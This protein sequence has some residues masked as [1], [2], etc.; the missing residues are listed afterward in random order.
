[1][2]VVPRAIAFREGKISGLR[3]LKSV[4]VKRY[5]PL[6]SLFVSN[7][8]IVEGGS[9]FTKCGE[10]GNSTQVSNV[11]QK[12]IYL[13]QQRE[14]KLGKGRSNILFFPTVYIQ[15]NRERESWEKEEA[16]FCFS[17]PET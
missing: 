4:P 8:F 7:E 11:T 16:I 15:L 10:G 12:S 3:T 17:P 1:M 6:Y 14:G 9:C 2:L 13:T 5:T